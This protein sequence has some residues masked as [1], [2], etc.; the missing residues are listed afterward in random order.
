[1]AG[2]PEPFRNIHGTA[3]AVGGKGALIRGPS[4]SGKS[5]LALRCLYLGR[6]QLSSE[7]VQLIADDQI[8]VHRDGPHVLLSSPG[9][10]VGLIEVRGIGI[11]G[12]PSA[13][14]VPLMLVVD[15]V[16][17]SEPISRLPEPET[18]IIDGVAIARIRLHPFEQSAAIKLLLALSLQGKTTW[19][20]AL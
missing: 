9:S 20:N 11:V 2:A 1:M 18:V 4:G 6:S 12:T 7:P 8:L 10:I 15:L 16:P 14:T 13:P 3:L 17:T 19:Q 5:D